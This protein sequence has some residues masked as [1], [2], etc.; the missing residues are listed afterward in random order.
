MEALMCKSSDTCIGMDNVLPNEKEKQDFKHHGYYLG[1]TRQEPSLVL[2]VLQSSLVGLEESEAER[3]LK[4]YGRNEFPES[5][6]GVLL[7]IYHA[8]VNPF[9]FLLLVLAFITYFTGSG[10]S[11]DIN[12]LLMCLMIFLSFIVTFVQEYRSSSATQRLKKMITTKATVLRRHGICSKEMEIPLRNIV[13]GDIIILSAGDMIPADIRILESK[14]L[15]VSQS[16]LTGESMPIEK[17]SSYQEFGGGLFDQPTLCFM[18]TNVVSGSATA[19]VMKTGQNVYLGT[20]AKSIVGRPSMTNFDRDVRRYVFFMFFVIVIMAPLVFII[21]YITKRDLKDSLLFAVSIAVGLTPEMLPMIV[22]VNLA[23]GGNVM[24]DKKVVIKR[25]NV[26][27]NLGSVDVLCTDKTGTLTEDKISVMK[28]LGPDGLLDQISLKLAYLNSRFQTGLKNLLDTAV[29]DCAHISGLQDYDKYYVK[30]DEI[31][32]DFIRKRMSVVLKNIS[33]SQKILICKGAV[34]DVLALCTA[35]IIAG[36]QISLESSRL[37]QILNMCKEMNQQGL[38]VIAVAT[39]EFPLECTQYEFFQDSERDMVFR[40]FVAFLD[41]PKSTA[42]EAI[43]LLQQSGISMKVLTG[44]NDA[45]AKTVCSQVG[46]VLNRVVLGSELDSMCELEL[47]EVVEEAQLFA[48]LTPMHK[49]RIVKALQSN[50]HVVGF[51]GDGINDAPALKEADAGISVD[52]AV[53]IAKE[54]ADIILMEKNLLVLY[55]GVIEGRKVFANILKYIKMGISSNFGNVFSVV[56]A[57]ALLPFL[58][59]NP[60]QLL[61][62]NLLYDISQIAI[63]W[64]NVDPEFLAAPHKWNIIKDIG[65]FMI[66]IGPISSL[67]DYCIF[68]LMWWYFGCQ[69]PNNNFQVSLFHTGWFIEGLLTQTLIVHIIRTHKVPLVSSRPSLSLALTTLV[70]VAVGIAIP[71]TKLGSILGLVPMPASYFGFLFLFIISYIF[72]T[73][74]CKSFYV[75]KFGIY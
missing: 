13:P 25:L 38:R 65:R 66:C 7:Q 63:P 42:M 57:S 14:D 30:L 5:R 36:K 53:D 26:V 1:I 39:K 61:A 17:F 43:W 56:G 3:R 70:V 48:K 54:A 16:A 64:D 19:V 74:T 2:D 72:L 67:F 62:Q 10:G 73:Q 18:G 35:T 29:I 51:L 50:G 15:Y 71:F 60:I 44:D 52:N 8:L 34:E 21:N 41:P 40:G 58:P 4:I 28:Y 11:D 33:T 12:A 31:P 47:S 23:K 24:A 32:F 27:Q 37:D 9:N 75:K 68:A 46:I 6:F 55:D 59:M 45:V 20:V 49:L 69:D 22:A